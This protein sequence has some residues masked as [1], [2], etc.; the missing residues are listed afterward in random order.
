MLGIT[1]LTEKYTVIYFFVSFV[2]FVDNAQH[3]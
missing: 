2:L 1:L 3:Q